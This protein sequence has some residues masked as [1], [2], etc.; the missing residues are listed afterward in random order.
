MSISMLKGEF[1]SGKSSIVLQGR[2]CFSPADTWMGAGCCLQT[3]SQWCC[4]RGF[5]E[6][7]ACTNTQRCAVETELYCQFPGPEDLRS[8]CMYF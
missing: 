2:F 4:G 7:Y 6:G 1:F 3:R 5:V 8:T